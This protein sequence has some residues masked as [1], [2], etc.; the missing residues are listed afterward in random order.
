MATA[1]V[2]ANLGFRWHSRGHWSTREDR[3]PSLVWLAFIWSGMLA[4]F[5]LDASRFLHG[6]P[7]LLLHV[8]AFVFTVWLFILS[9]QVTLVVTNRVALHRRLGWF[10]AAWVVPMAIL[11][12]WAALTAKGPIPSGPP[13]PQFL[14][15]QFGGLIAFLAFI[16]WGLTLRKNPAAHKRIMILSTIAI[17]DPGFGRLAMILWPTEPTSLLGWFLWNYAANVVLLA[18]M[19]AW[20]LYRGRLM[21]Q[22]VFGAAALLVFEYLLVFLYFWTPWKVFT[23]SLVASWTSLVR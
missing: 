11:G 20:D 18:L 15:I 21:K 4:G 8:H 6:N 16:A 9:A 1:P 12:P 2:K 14:S 13:S 5:G 10:A 23:T 19:A 22:L 3:L 7:P 17:Q